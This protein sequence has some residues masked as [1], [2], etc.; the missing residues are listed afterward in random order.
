MRIFMSIVFIAIAASSSA[1]TDNAQS[2]IQLPLSFEP[3][4]G[5]AARDVAF[6]ANGSA[7]RFELTGNGARIT[8]WNGDSA[9]RIV[10]TPVNA[11]TNPR[12]RAL[13][14]LP[15][16]SN[17]LVGPEAGWIKDVPN[18]G[19]VEYEDV[20]PGI[21]VAYYGNDRTFEYDFIVEAEADPDRIRIRF[22]GAD[23]VA[24]DPS[25]ELVLRAGKTSIRHSRPVSYQEIDGRRVPVQS[26]YTVNA[27]QEVGF[28][29]AKYDRRHPVTIDPAMLYGSY[30]GT[31]ASDY[32]SGI[33]VDNSGAIY[34]TQ[35]VY[36]GQMQNGDHDARVIKI[37]PDGSGY[38]TTFGSM[39]MSEFAYGVAVNNSGE[40]Y[41]VGSADTGHPASMVL[42]NTL[43]P[44][45]G[46]RNA[47]IIKFTAAGNAFIFSSYFGGNVEDSPTAVSLDSN[48]NIIVAGLTRSPNFPTVA[49]HDSTL[50]GSSDGFLV[51]INAAA[52]AFLFST[53]LGGSGDDGVAGL[54]VDA[55]GNIVV[56][57]KTNS[58]D[59]F[60][61]P[62]HPY[63]GSTAFSEAF[64]ASFSGVNGSLQAGT[65][66]GGTAS[67]SGRAIDI[68][69]SGNV[70]V[71]GETQS[72]DFP[73]RGM[74]Y[75]RKLLGSTDAFIARL[76]PSL[77]LRYGT[78]LGGMSNESASGVRVDATNAIY[79]TGRTDSE[80][81]PLVDSL[82]RAGGLFL[83][84]MSASGQSLVYSTRIA[85]TSQGVDLALDSAAN[86]FVIGETISTEL[87][88]TPN[89]YQAQFPY[90]GCRFNFQNGVLLKIGGAT[91]ASKPS[92]TLIEQNDPSVEYNGRWRVDLSSEAMHTNKI[93]VRAAAPGSRAT[94]TFAGVGITW[95]GFR[96]GSSGIANV[97]LD[98]ALLGK[99]DSYIS[100][101][102][103]Q[104]P[105]FTIDGLSNTT[106]TLV[107][108]AA[109]QKNPASSNEWIWV[110][111]F[112]VQRTGSAGSGSSAGFTR[113]AITPASF[114]YENPEGI[115]FE[116]AGAAVRFV[117]RSRNACAYP[118]DSQ[119]RTYVDGVPVTFTVLEVDVTGNKIYSISGLGPGSHTLR[120]APASTNEFIEVFVSALD[121]EIT[122]P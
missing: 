29:L 82:S 105:L 31:G 8:L 113:R 88:V 86:A 55:S 117:G 74:P 65:F 110:D 1:A 9:K 14:R 12:S 119:I 75:Q 34:A 41:V 100:G 98:G 50:N 38:N 5:Q 99:V 107:I 69:T 115:T 66:I 45:P 121:E 53:Y 32:S 101:E 76:N 93:A 20:Y 10:M 114:T 24:I 109:G 59:L 61:A 83:T 87:P 43:G 42:Q 48:G 81:F 25:G 22:E 80:D 72:P 58:S 73:V 84:K 23:G 122:A 33:A 18:Y 19:R 90:D 52:T 2:P 70:Y 26:S 6:V 118:F 62:V 46:A 36:W 85:N 27:N 64:V 35:S 49:A 3:N 120:I 106:H 30:W 40:A 68:D 13:Q 67:D 112:V 28:K 92:Y 56:T 108:E 16:T 71:V 103:Y 60:S 4:Q 96:D 44:P 102:R 47:Y 11:R 39:W 51:K 63:S 94:V 21:D 15:R 91:V 104:Y 17:Y 78:Y 89:A 111:A 37:A 77:Q 7:Y 116:F 95:I 54:R 57:G 97:Y 79:V